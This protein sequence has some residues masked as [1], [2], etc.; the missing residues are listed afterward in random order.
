MGFIES[1]KHL[2]KICGEIMNDDRRLS[3]YID[4]MLRK[5]NSAFYVNGWNDDLKQLKHYRWVRNQIAHEPGCTE[6]NMCEPSD[7]IWLDNFYARIMN[8]TDPLALYYQATKHQAQHPSQMQNQV[9]I[10]DTS[11]SNTYNRTYNHNKKNT[12]KPVGYITFIVC[13]LFIAAIIIYLLR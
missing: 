6:Q 9:Q 3:A 8:Q 2:E 7:T 4:E 5:P 11:T 1:Y 12:H 13:A 10:Y